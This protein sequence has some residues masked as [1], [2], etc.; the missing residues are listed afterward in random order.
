MAIFKGST[1]GNISKS[2]G[3]A[4]GYRLKGQNIVR[5]KPLS[6]NDKNS[7][8]QQK[9]RLRQTTLVQRSREVAAIYANGYPSRPTKWSDYNAFVSYSKDAVSVD[10]SLDITYDVG[11]FS[12][13]KGNAQKLDVTSFSYAGNDIVMTNSTES[14]NVTGFDSDKIHIAGFNDS[15]NKFT[16]VKRDASTRGA[17][18]FTLADA[19]S[20]ISHL[21]LYAES[22]DGNVSDSQMIELA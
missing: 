13:A 21:I 15:E 16:L 11:E 19:P 10:D 7:L 5:Q 12:L 8:S 17:S 18:T 1:F 14:D 3:E 20:D 9:T 2:I 22:L 6:Y 4:V